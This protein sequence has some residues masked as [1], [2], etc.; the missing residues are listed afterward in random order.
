MCKDDGHTEA[1]QIEFDPDRISYE[2]LLGHFWQEH[3]PSPNKL[4]Q[5]KSVIFTNGSDQQK[6]AVAM[7]ASRKQVVTEILPAK[8]WNDAEEYHQNYFKEQKWGRANTGKP[9]CVAP[10]SEENCAI[11]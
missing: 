5:Y 11:M 4:A 7:A 6:A 3:H 9:V 8:K 10:K 2:S 1:I